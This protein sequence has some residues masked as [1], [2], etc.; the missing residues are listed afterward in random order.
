MRRK[1]SPEGMQFLP[2]LPSNTPV[3]IYISSLSNTQLSLVRAWGARGRAPY[4]FSEATVCGSWPHPVTPY[5]R[6]ALCRSPAGAL[7]WKLCI[8]PPLCRFILLR[9]TVSIDCD[10][11]YIFQG[12]FKLRQPFSK[13]FIW[14]TEEPCCHLYWL[15]N[16]LQRIFKNHW[17]SRTM[18]TC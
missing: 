1:G 16:I 17:S 9:N 2:I 6:T 5:L 12:L 10:M 4:P 15:R 11:K 7:S 3:Y 14:D 8:L 13:V 18:N